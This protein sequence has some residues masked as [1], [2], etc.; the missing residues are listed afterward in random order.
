M[1]LADNKLN[2]SE[3]DEA[4]L[5]EELKELEKDFDMADFGFFDNEELHSIPGNLDADDEM[6]EDK[7][8]SVKLTFPNF[9][10]YRLHET[11][12]K[13]IAEEFGA[14]FSVIKV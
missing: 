7:P 9:T 8:V 2:E 13:E 6:D 5:E 10:E 1:R 14:T 3:W 11:E 12:V 4:L